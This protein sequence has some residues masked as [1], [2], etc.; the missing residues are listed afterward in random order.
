MNSFDAF[1]VWETQCFTD[2]DILYLST[3]FIS[4]VIYITNSTGCRITY[5]FNW[6]VDEMCFLFLVICPLVSW[7]NCVYEG[8][9]CLLSH[10]FNNIVQMRTNFNLKKL[11]F[12]LVW[13]MIEE[14]KKGV[15][16]KG[17]KRQ[18]MIYKTLHIRLQMEEI[19]G[20]THP[21][22]LEW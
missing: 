2:T 5:N 3:K 11:Y 12:D 9:T 20:W 6:K 21:S 15:K 14:T 17:T 1:I 7:D 13:E 8:K 22:V 4:F 10:V 18:T 16:M 19:Q